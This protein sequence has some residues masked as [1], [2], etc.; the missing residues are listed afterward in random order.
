MTIIP[1]LLALSVVIFFAIYR[2]YAKIRSKF[3]TFMLIYNAVNNIKNEPAAFTINDT[4]KSGSI[5]YSR[6]GRQYIINFPYESGFVVDMSG[7]KVELIRSDNSVV[8]ITQQ[9]GIAYICTAASLGGE[10]IRVTN[11]NTGS[12][13]VYSRDEPPGYGT[14][15]LRTD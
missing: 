3:S 1:I 8:D 12:G 4:Q 9:P 6:L 14:V 5:V 15:E 13:K 11:T 10:Y 2:N 7:W